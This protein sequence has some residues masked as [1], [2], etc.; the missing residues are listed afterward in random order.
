MAATTG[1]LFKDIGPTKLSMIVGL[2]LVLVAGFIFLAMK[3]ST[4]ALTPLFGNLD[5]SDSAKISAQLESAGIYYEVRAGG[6]QI[7]VPNDKVLSTRMMLAKEGLPSNNATVGYE[8]FDKSETM[9]VSSFVQNVNFMRALEG[10]LARTISSFSSVETA[11]VHLV[12]PKN[13]YF[14][15]S[16]EQPSASIVLTLRGGKSLSDQEV[17]AISHL[18]ATA[19]PDLNV[20]MIT[21]VDTQGRPFKKGAEDENDPGVMASNSAQYRVSFERHIKSVIEDMLSRTV[22]NGRVEAQVSAEMNFDREVTDSETFDPDGQVARSV[23]NSE[24]KGTSTEGGPGGNVSVSG[25]LPGTEAVAGAN[26]SASNNDKT[27]E[28]TNFE[29]SKTQKKHI[30]ETGTLKKLSI[31]VLVDGNYATDDKTGEVKYTPRSDTDLKAIE[32]LVKSA[33]GFND[34]RGDKIDVINMRFSSEEAHFDKPKPFEWI[35]KDLGNIIQT[36]VIGIIITLVILLI[37]KPMV[38]KAFEITKAESSEADL[39]K[40]LAGGE[41]EELEELTGEVEG[42]RKKNEPLVNIE[43]LEQRMNTSSLNAINDIVDRHPQ[44]AVTILRSWMTEAE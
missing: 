22:G 32:G 16:K 37:I 17:S 43:S 30:Q 29:I 42:L 23:Q 25:N 4:P 31:A 35:T 40:A 8:I 13:N 1:Q 20:N 10:E 14:S 36:L 28:I 12:I 9:G 3:L 24:D 39:Q 41:L 5:T 7:L 2:G 11:R 21:I 38:G 27:N 15:R 18:V 33:V 34:T 6:S 44:E 19:V 26:K